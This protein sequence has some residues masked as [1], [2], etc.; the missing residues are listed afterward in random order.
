MRTISDFGHAGLQLRLVPFRK[1]L[2]IEAVVLLV[3]LVPVPVP[4]SVPILVSFFV[5]RFLLLFQCGRSTAPTR[6]T[7]SAIEPCNCC[8]PRGVA[9]SES[10]QEEAPLFGFESLDPGRQESER[11]GTESE[12]QDCGEDE[13]GLSNE[14]EG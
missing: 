10:E 14:G 2:R 9:R 1:V 4:V 13:E 8:S 6:P 12:S 7:E 3:R 11:V 5:D